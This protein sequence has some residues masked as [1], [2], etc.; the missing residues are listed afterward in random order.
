[1]T[2]LYQD[3]K[4][5]IKSLQK[6]LILLKTIMSSPGEVGIIELQKI[7]GYNTS[8]I[9]HALKTLMLEGFVSQNKRTKKYTIGP[10]LFN[11]WVKQNKLNNYIYRAYP[12][13]EETVSEIGETTSLFIQREH[14]SICV[15]GKESSHM[16]RAFLTIGR[17]IPLHCTAT[18]KVFLANMDPNKLDEIIYQSDLKEYMPNTITRPEFLKKELRQIKD[19]G[20]ALEF[21]EFEEMINAIG[22]PVFNDD[23]DVISVITII[24]P[25]TRLT[26]EKMLSIYPILIEKAKKISSILTGTAF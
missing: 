3:E 16:L 4:G 21:E 10:E 15:I 7:C 11:I 14:E 2:N 20:F 26:R 12:I 17:R 5:I 22:A 1:M 8:S 9:H 23:G 24:A 19:Q 6:S 25:L 13:L 18:G